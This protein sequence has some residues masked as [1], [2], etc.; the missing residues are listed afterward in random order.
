MIS[1]QVP[2]HED[3]LDGADEIAEFV[4]GDRNQRRRVYYLA[5]RGLI[6]VTR[7]GRLISSTKSA[8]RDSFTPKPA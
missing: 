8:I 6:P 7:K 4:F 3:L 1:T 2:F 5:D